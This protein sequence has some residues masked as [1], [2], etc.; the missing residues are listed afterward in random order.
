MRLKERVAIVT[1]GGSGIGEGICTCMA[2]EGADIVISDINFETAK[3]VADRL[4]QFGGRALAIQTD[5]R[6]NE[7]CRKMIEESL[8]K[9]K[10]IDILVCC[11]GVPG[12]STKNISENVTR[13]ENISETD[14]DL[15]LETNLKGVFLCN[16]SIIP[17]FK[18]RNAGKIINISSIAGRRG[19]DWIP[20]YSA[21][22]AGII[23]LSQAIAAQVGK[24]NVNVNTIC[25]G[26]IW[27]PMSVVAG[28]I[29]AKTYSQFHHLS[30]REIFDETIKAKVPL[31]RP[32]TPEAIGQLAVFLAS[33]EAS[34]ITGQAINV[35][36]GAVFN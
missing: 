2:R 33:E 21:S 23:V 6:K 12:Y 8:S 13:I 11:A 32:Q 16:R 10:Q 1:G 35:D 9:M 26:F 5:V 34:E 28:Q 30:P 15:T 3:Q 19:S 27:T 24:Y 31:G 20:H 18:Q 36:G 25:P 4:K 29:M 7:D 17:Y 14:W 22:K